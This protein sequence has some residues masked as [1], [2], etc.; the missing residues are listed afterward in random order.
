MKS[1]AAFNFGEIPERHFVMTT[2]HEHEPLEEV[3]WF[4]KNSA[5]TASSSVEIADTVILHGLRRGSGCACGSIEWYALR[6]DQA[7]NGAGSGPR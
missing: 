6:D 5:S 3:F 1:I 7:A 4:A 2:W